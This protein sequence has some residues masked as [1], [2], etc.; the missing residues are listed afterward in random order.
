MTPATR[1]RAALAGQPVDRLPVMLHNFQPAIR[2]IGA[3]HAQYRSDPAVMAKAHN[4]SAAAFNLDGILVDVDTALVAG[5]CG[6][7]ADLPEDQPARIH[8]WRFET[9]AAS[10]GVPV[11]DLST[12]PRIAVLV[13]GVRLIKQAHGDRLFIRGNCDQGPF[14]LAALVCRPEAFLM[15]AIDP[16]QAEDV[17]ALLD[18]CAAV[19]DQMLGLMATSGCDMLSNGDSTAGPDVLSPRWFR[20]WVAP[21]HQALAARAHALGR[22]YLMHVCGNTTAILADLVASGPDALELDYKTDLAAVARVCPGKAA[23]FGNLDP[24]GV[25]ARGTPDQVTAA[26]RNLISTYGSRS[27]VV[28]AGCALPPGTPDANIQAL[29]AAAHAG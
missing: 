16:E 6:A 10:R 26:T 14:S 20:R 28:G 8:G 29:V 9:P 11:P 23:L 4:E 24:S 3:T 17:A 27:L 5:A 13:E 25:M 1:I 21:R 18:W 12:D 19:C 2:R 22:T 15:A 7:P